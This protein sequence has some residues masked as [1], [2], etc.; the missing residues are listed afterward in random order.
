MLGL[1][2]Y[3]SLYVWIV[4]NEGENSF[5]RLTSTFQKNS[6]RHGGLAWLSTISL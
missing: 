6:G 4:N 3:S 2:K 1:Y 5:I